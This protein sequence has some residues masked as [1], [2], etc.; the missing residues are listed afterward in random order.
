[1]SLCVNTSAMAFHMLLTTEPQERATVISF[2]TTH[3]KEGGYVWLGYPPVLLKIAKWFGLK[4][5]LDGSWDISNDKIAVYRSLSPNTPPAR[6]RCCSFVAA[7]YKCQYCPPMVP[8]S[9]CNTL[10][11]LDGWGNTGDK[12]ASAV[13]L[14][15]QTETSHAE[16]KWPV[17]I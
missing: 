14:Q 7:V 2:C 16:E 11:K 17:L 15:W 3:Y 8:V 4:F 9:W 6:C 10:V 12:A 1:M 5:A 13:S